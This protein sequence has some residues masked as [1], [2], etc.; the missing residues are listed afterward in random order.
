VTAICVHTAGRGA[1]RHSA[2]R[3]Q[4]AGARERSWNAGYTAVV[5]Q[6]RRDLLAWRRPPPDDE[7]RPRDPSARAAELDAWARRAGWR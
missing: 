4:A 1:I 6:L 5:E 3:S 2:R 7:P